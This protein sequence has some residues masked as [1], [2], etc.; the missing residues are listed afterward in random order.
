MTL[1]T[2]R[3]ELLVVSGDLTSQ[4]L[5]ISHRHRREKSEGSSSVGRLLGSDSYWA[6][7]P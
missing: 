5:V 6:I 1:E 3:E 7:E 2:C 4:G